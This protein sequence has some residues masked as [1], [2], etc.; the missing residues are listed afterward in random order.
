MAKSKGES[1]EIPMAN[2]RLSYPH[3]WVAQRFDEANDKEGPKF[4]ATLIF[5]K[6]GDIH[7]VIAAGIKRVIT[8]MW[9]EGRP[10]SLKHCLNDGATRADKDGYSADVMFINA[11]SADRFTVIDRNKRPLVASDGKPY[12]GCYVNAIVRLW[13]QDNKFGKRVNAQP[14]GV[15]F[16]RDGDAFGGAGRVASP[17][18]FDIFDDGSTENDDD[19]LNL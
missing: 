18:D 7:E 9:P 6:G 2:V 14:L 5:P 12:A 8:S 15:Q 4:S 19:P 13:P 10:A 1:V 3:L 16:W 11:S 17:D